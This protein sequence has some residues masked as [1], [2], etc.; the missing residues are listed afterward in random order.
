MSR[1]GWEEKE[2]GG[3]LFE[4]VVEAE[5]E[6]MADAG[7]LNA[8]SGLVVDIAWDILALPGHVCG[9][10]ASIWTAAPGVSNDAIEG[11]SCWAVVSSEA[12][13]VERVDVAVEVVAHDLLCLLRWAGG[14]SGRTDPLERLSMAPEFE[15]PQPRSAK[16]C[17]FNLWS[18]WS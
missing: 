10:R 7:V 15:R 2:G 12:V 3:G 5:S 9:E 1:R 16:K 11:W 18:C 6:N 8:V 13:K 4:D 14:C 17:S